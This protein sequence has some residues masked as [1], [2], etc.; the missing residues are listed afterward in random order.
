[1]G[2]NSHC[3]TPTNTILCSQIAPATL[4]LP[5]ALNR[6]V[7]AYK[8]RRFAEAEQLC[9]AILAVK[10]D[11]FDAL[12]LLAVAQTMSGHGN[13]ALVTYDRALALRPDHAEALFNRA[14][15]L[16][17]LRRFEEAL[18][19]YERALALRPD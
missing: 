3:S 11:V 18:A 4:T 9:L 16:Q 7:A 2:Q 15:S 13:D 6:A 10:Q 8:E 19:S 17:K 5:E 14:V 12:H 1:M